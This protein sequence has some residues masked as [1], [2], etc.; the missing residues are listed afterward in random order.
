MYVDIGSKGWENLA[1]ALKEH[2]HGEPYKLQF[3]SYNYLMIQARS[4]D[5]QIIWEGML[6]GSS[7][8]VK[9]KV[10]PR[11]EFFKGSEDAE[12]ERTW[13]ELVKFLQNPTE[14]R[15][16]MRPT[17]ADFNPFDKSTKNW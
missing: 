3:R 8:F 12:N 10:G 6:E 9:S 14:R 11:K 17:T 5:L 13:T 2:K 7:F 4:E 15:S 16:H 1:Q